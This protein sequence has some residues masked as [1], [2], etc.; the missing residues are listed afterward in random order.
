M[1]LQITE[2]STVIIFILSFIQTVHGT[3]RSKRAGKMS[4]YTVDRPYDYTSFKCFY[5]D[6][7]PPPDPETVPPATERPLNFKYWHDTSLWNKTGDSNS[8]TD[9]FVTSDGGS[10]GEPQ[11]LDNVRIVSGK[12]NYGQED[13]FKKMLCNYISHFIYLSFKLVCVTLLFV[14]SM[15][16]SCQIL[17]LIMVYLTFSHMKQICSR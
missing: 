13:I 10:Y 14:I 12:F 6:C 9:I 2:L 7:I 3:T 16:V 1:Y 5:P 4:T 15:F 17:I 8:S 11:E